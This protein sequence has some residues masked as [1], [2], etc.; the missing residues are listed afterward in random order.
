M[1]YLPF[2]IQSGLKQYS[3]ASRL[4]LP[5]ERAW[6]TAGEAAGLCSYCFHSCCCGLRSAVTVGG[7]GNHSIQRPPRGS[8][9]GSRVT[10]WSHV[11]THILSSLGRPLKARGLGSWVTSRRGWTTANTCG[12]TLERQ[13]MALRPQTTQNPVRPRRT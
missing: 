9:P 12:P 11:C 2:S 8:S 6:G 3:R 4:R 13:V 7:Q 10:P 1:S 5:E